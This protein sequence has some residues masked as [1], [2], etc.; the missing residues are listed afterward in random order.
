MDERGMDQAVDAY[1]ANDPYYPRPPP[2]LRKPQG[3]ALFDADSPV[4][5]LQLYEDGE[6]WATFQTGTSP[7]VRSF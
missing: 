7:P 5:L 1:F 4:E 3:G 2:H 6:N